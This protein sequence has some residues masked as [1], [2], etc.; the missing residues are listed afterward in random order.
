MV[1]LAR[2]PRLPRGRNAGGRTRRVGP[3]ALRNPHWQRDLQRQLPSCVTLPA[4]AFEVSQEVS[5]TAL[6]VGVSLCRVSRLRRSVSRSGAYRDGDADGLVRIRLAA[7]EYAQVAPRPA[8][9]RANL[10]GG[11]SRHVPPRRSAHEL[12]PRS[13]RTR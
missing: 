4:V 2:G 11:H 7:E 3:S 8:I 6:H 12:H 1:A 5:P 10:R 13:P 9:V